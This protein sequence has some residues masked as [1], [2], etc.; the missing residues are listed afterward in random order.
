MGDPSKKDSILLGLLAPL[1][2]PERIQH[3]GKDIGFAVEAFVRDYNRAMDQAPRGDPRPLT[4]VIC[5][6][7]ADIER[8]IAHLLETIRVKGI[9]G[10]F[11]EAKLNSIAK[12]TKEANV[13]VMSPFADG[14]RFKDTHGGS[15]L[16]WSCAPNRL[17]ALSYLKNLL[18]FVVEHI[19]EKRHPG[20]APVVALYT[21][22]DV[23]ASD[24]TD[25]AFNANLFPE[26]PTRINYEYFLTQ[27]DTA[28]YTIFANKAIEEKANLIVDLGSG[29]GRFSEVVLEIE[30]LWKSDAGS[31]QPYYVSYQRSSN[32]AEAVVWNMHSSDGG[33]PTDLDIFQRTLVFDQ[34]RPTSAELPYAAF[35]NKVKGLAK[36]DPDEQM[37]LAYDCTFALALG[38]QAA[39]T[40][41]S[42]SVE[43]VTGEQFKAGMLRLFSANETQFRV[44][45]ESLLD[46][47]QTLSAGG[48]VDAIGA[49]GELAFNVENGYPEPSEGALWCFRPT[50]DSYWKAEYSQTG[51]TFSSKD[52]KREGEFSC[53]PAW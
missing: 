24:M 35:R 2:G 1:T 34:P 12:K 44:G 40:T 7:T 14:P 6:E 18:N 19:R 28:D 22:D 13:V 4:V 41:Q 5:D 51:V 33:T 21:S 17:G 16:V 8:A 38:L 9:V 25:M 31:I 15:G 29:L 26:P 3:L 27:P 42:I 36:Y 10:P 30:T 46:I 43:S 11:D 37:E 52:G 32:L 48:K 53:P 20:F 50:L 47:F 39:R 23:A 49:S 45:D